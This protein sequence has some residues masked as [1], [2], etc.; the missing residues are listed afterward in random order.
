MS[1]GTRVARIRDEVTHHEPLT[2]AL[3]EDPLMSSVPDAEILARW[4]LLALPFNLRNDHC[5]AWSQDPNLLPSIPAIRTHDK[6]QREY[7][8]Q[9]GDDRRSTPFT[10]PEG[11]DPIG[12][13]RIALSG[14]VSI[15][16]SP[17][18]IPGFDDGL[19]V[20]AILGDRRHRA[21]KKQPQRGQNQQPHVMLLKLSP[22]HSERPPNTA[23]KLQEGASFPALRPLVSFMRL[24]G[25]ARLSSAR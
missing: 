20:R 10:H 6:W 25:D 1:S 14:K 17:A 19:D 22:A 13:V 11:V 16:R 12:I 9:L 15:L 23:H 18:F 5:H 4:R 24:L 3:D 7:F 2:V 8:L 21:R